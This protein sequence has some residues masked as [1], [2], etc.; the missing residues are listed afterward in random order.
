MRRRIPLWL[1]AATV[2]A[3]CDASGSTEGGALTEPD[4]CS[5]ADGGDT[6]TYLY[7][8]Y[9]GPGGKASCTG[10]NFCHGASTMTGAATSGYVCGS[11]REA[12]W[13]GMTQGA[14][15]CDAGATGSDASADAASEG[16]ATLEGGADA[17]D[18]GVAEAGAPMCTP[19]L[20]PI[21]PSGGAGDP[22]T[23]LLWPA[24]RGASGPGL[25]NMPYSANAGGVT[26]T[27]EDLD[28]ISAWIRAGAQDN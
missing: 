14:S 3:G 19:G 6:W 22:T 25:H 9:F 18:G 28:R 12:C 17:G 7:T 2:L 8:C 21:V 15:T 10:Q 26:F 1:L 11:S 24:L 4:P 16:G 27:P 5:G 13:R 23:T 20:P